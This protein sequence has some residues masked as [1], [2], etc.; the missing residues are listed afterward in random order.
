MLTACGEIATRVRLARVEALNAGGA[1]M[2]FYDP[3]LAGDI[4]SV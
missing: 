2:L 3:A 1:A 4:S